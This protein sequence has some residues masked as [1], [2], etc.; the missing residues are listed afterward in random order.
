MII[1]IRH[2]DKVK[3]ITK[4]YIKVKT[5]HSFYSYKILFKCKGF[6]GIVEIMSIL[7]P[8][9]GYLTADIRTTIISLIIG[10]IVYKLSKFYMKVFS[11]PPG[12]I[13]LPLI[14]NVLSKN[15]LSKL[16]SL[17]IYIIIGFRGTKDHWAT[18]LERIG[19]KYGHVFTMWMGITPV[20]FISD[21]DIAREA[22]R[23]NDF[24]GRP[25]SVFG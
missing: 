21:I 20:V 3:I 24:A 2:I 4:I 11:F 1:A 8:I 12:P 23:R 5:L 10:L 13:P 7:T 22:F 19:E 16:S 9:L 14:G 15:L 6:V 25:V 17:L 18:E